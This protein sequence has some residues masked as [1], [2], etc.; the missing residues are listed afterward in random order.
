MKYVYV[1]NWEVKDLPQYL[2]KSWSNVSNFDVFDNDTL[3]SYGWYPHKYVTVGVPDGYRLDGTE[4][5]IT[6][7]EV[8]ETQKVRLKT[9]QEIQ[10]EINSMWESVRARRNIELL[11]SDWTQIPDSPLS[12]EKKLEWS[13][14]RQALRDITLQTDPFAIA[15]PSKPL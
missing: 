4:F 14:Y 3:K 2:P 11:D 9:E 10:D 6:E 15:W 8:I 1:E 5:T 12:E 13:V 7:D